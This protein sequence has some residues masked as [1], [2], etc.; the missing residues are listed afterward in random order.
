MLRLISFFVVLI[1]SVVFGQIKVEEAPRSVNK[2]SSTVHANAATKSST[3]TTNENGTF[4]RTENRNTDGSITITKAM[5]QGPDNQP[6]EMSAQ[7][8]MLSIDRTIAAIQSKMEVVRT[9]PKYH[10]QA[11]LNGWYERQNAKIGTLKEKRRQLEIS[12]K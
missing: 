12:E 1:P 8:R 10:K 3:Q 5:N 4:I 6:T 7:E 2:N 9:T 11:T